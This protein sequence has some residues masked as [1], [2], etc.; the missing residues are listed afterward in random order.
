MPTSGLLSLGRYQNH[1]CLCPGHYPGHYPGHFSVLGPGPD[2][3]RTDFESVSDS[4]A[5]YRWQTDLAT[6]AWLAFESFVD[7]V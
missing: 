2:W 6:A 5:G 4:V 7:L 1:L 3:L